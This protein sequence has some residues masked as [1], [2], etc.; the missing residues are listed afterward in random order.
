MTYSFDL[1][2]ACLLVIVLE[3]TDPGL[4]RRKPLE[5]FRHVGFQPLGSRLFEDVRVDQLV[6]D[7]LRCGL[8]RKQGVE[9]L[10]RTTE[11][12][13]PPSAEPPQAG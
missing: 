8:D 13:G 9:V 11:Q 4:D 6:A 10:G 3:Q 5:L 12:L 2:L 7:Q 1:G